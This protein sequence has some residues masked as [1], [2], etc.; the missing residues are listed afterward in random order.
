MYVCMY[1]CMCVCMLRVAVAVLKFFPLSQLTRVV[2]PPKP[3]PTPAPPGGLWHEW[4]TV[5][6]G[7]RCG[8]CSVFAPLPLNDPELELLGCAGSPAAFVRAL[9]PSPEPKPC[10]PLPAPAGLPSRLPSGNGLDSGGPQLNVSHTNGH[11]MFRVVFDKTDPIVYCRLCGAYSASRVNKALLTTCA[12]S[13]ST[14]G[15]V[16]LARLNAGRHPSRVPE[17]KNCFVIG[18]PTP[19]VLTKEQTAGGAGNAARSSSAPVR[20][21][22]VLS[23]LLERV[24]V[25]EASEI[26]NSV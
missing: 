16:V 1:V 13:P 25:R 14:S 19:A 4:S 8:V 5:P 10:L 9:R 6:G 24:R 23:T 7:V 20:P 17:L 11:R 12:G 3:K 18:Q 15:K 26:P 22:R 21:I 2:V